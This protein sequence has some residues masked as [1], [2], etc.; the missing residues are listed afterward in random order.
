MKNV[1]I[2][3]STPRVGG[4][5]E[6]LANEFAKGA[7]E[8]GHS[9]EIIKLREYNLNEIMRKLEEYG[10]LDD[11]F[12]GDVYVYEEEARRLLAKRNITPKLQP[13]LNSL[14]TATLVTLQVTRKPFIR[15]P[16]V[17]SLSMYVAV[18]NLFIPKKISFA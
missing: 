3:S 17:F 10:F 14:L 6:V 2:I 13:S 15:H 12:N 11:R 8:S 18:K 4:N 16:T 7:I 9:V 1:V 5:S